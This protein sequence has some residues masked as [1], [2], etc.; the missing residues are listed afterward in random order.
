MGKSW[1]LRCARTL[2]EGGEHCASST[3]AFTAPSDAFRTSE[4]P[5]Q[6]RAVASRHEEPFATAHCYTLIL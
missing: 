3:R 6:L 4:T 1:L 5:R 2:G